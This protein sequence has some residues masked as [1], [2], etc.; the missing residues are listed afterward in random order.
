[1]NQRQDHVLLVYYGFD[2]RQ[3]LIAA[4]AKDA[5]NKLLGLFFRV[6]AALKIGAVGLSGVWGPIWCRRALHWSWRQQ[7]PQSPLLVLAVTMEDALEPQSTK[8]YSPYMCLKPGP[9]TNEQRFITGTVLFVVI[10]GL[11]IATCKSPF[12]VVFLVD[13][14][15]VKFLITSPLFLEFS[16]LLR[17]SLSWFPPTTDS[18]QS[19]LLPFLFSLVYQWQTLPKVSYWPS[20]FCTTSLLTALTLKDSNL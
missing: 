11:L 10:N 15:V 1:M 20:S 4:I 19:P 18:L 7:V 2:Q 6:Y 16:W 3:E 9:M 17:H 5:A 12:S 14:A 8:E 13:S